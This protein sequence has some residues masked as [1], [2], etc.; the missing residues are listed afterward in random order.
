MDYERRHRTY[1]VPLGDWLKLHPNELERDAVGLWQIVPVGK[2]EFLL[3]GDDLKEFIGQAII[4]LLE[5]GAVP[6]TG[7][8]NGWHITEEYGVVRDS[9]V[10]NVL[11]RWAS[12]ESRDP[13]VGDL[14]FATREML[15]VPQK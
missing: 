6:V 8:E 10:Q 9:I 5:K 13:D 15:E 3:E 14:W 7:D 1:G 4:S 2:Y 11:E 12:S